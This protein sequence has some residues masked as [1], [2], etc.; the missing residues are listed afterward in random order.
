MLLRRQGCLL[1][2]ILRQL[3]LLLQLLLWRRRFGIEVRQGGG[4]VE[5]VKIGGGEV[6]KRVGGGGQSRLVNAKRNQFCTRDGQ[7][8]KTL[9]NGSN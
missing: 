3:L 1:T 7:K 6:M 8:G 2:L 9:A 4:F 5:R